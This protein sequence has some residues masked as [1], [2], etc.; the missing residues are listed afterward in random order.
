MITRRHFTALA[1]TALLG[2]CARRLPEYTGPEVTHLIVYKRDRR[3]IVMHHDKVLRNFPVQLGNQPEGP[4]QIQGDGRT[5][6]GIYWINRRNPR[7]QYHLS[8]GI[9]YPQ[10]DDVARALAMGQHPGGDIFIHGTPREHREEQ[11]WTAGCIA[12]SN[13][14]VEELWVMVRDGTPILLLP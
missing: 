6:E 2:A 8:L 3:L 9:S 14:Q 12:V 10:Q 5:P 11:D 13:A 1:A 7:S 4:K